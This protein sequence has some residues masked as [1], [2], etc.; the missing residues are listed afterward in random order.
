[1][2]NKKDN[3]I[4][5][6]LLGVFITGLGIYSYNLFGKSGDNN[7]LSVAYELLFKYALSG[8]LFIIGIKTIFVGIKRTIAQDE[9][10]EFEYEE[11]ITNIKSIDNEVKT[12]SE[13]ITFDIQKDEFGVKK[14]YNFKKDVIG[15]TIR[16]ERIIKTSYSDYV[17]DVKNKKLYFETLILLMK[18]IQLNDRS[19]DITKNRFYVLALE[20]A[21]EVED[22]D[23]VEL[24]KRIME[25]IINCEIEF[26]DFENK[27]LLS[28]SLDILKGKFAISPVITNLYFKLFSVLKIPVQNDEHFFYSLLN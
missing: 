2:G 9:E 23:A 27:Y 7:A 1:M 11:P 5:Q 16:T 6:A 3:P 25:N 8:F 17:C 13:N 14:T 18:F 22:M 26:N 24:E 21:S 4:S 12:E 28:N 15:S 10:D 20:H 19:V